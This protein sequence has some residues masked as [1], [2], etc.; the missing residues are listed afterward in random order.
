MPNIFDVGFDWL[1]SQFEE[2]TA[3]EVVYTRGAVSANVLASVGS[4]EFDVQDNFGVYQ[5]VTSRDYLIKATSLKL[6]D[7]VVTPQRGDLITDNGK[8]YE[9]LSMDGGQA[10]RYCDPYGNGLR[11]H[12]KE[13][14]S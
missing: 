14:D 9:V 8:T 10:W 5:R 11:I 4:T 2:H 6:A 13:V 12:T 3:S 1:A 7:Q